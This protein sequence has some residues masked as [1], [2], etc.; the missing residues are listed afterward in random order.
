MR[1]AFKVVVLLVVLGVLA[2]GLL[3]PL[4]DQGHLRDDANGAAQAG[5][6][7]V[8][9][10]GS[11][12]ASIGQTVAASIATHPGITLASVNVHGGVVTVVVK[13]KVHTFMSGTPGLEHWFQLTVTESASAFGPAG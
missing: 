4:I 11:T 2:A 9:K 3:P 1:L 8:L 12:P 10:S 5:A 6:A 13:Q 7:L